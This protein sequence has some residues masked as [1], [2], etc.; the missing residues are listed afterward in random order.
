M[1]GLQLRILVS[2]ACGLVLPA[3]HQGNG[4]AQGMK[5]N[6]RSFSVTEVHARSE[7]K[8]SFCSGFTLTTTQAEAFF[9]R[10][11][12]IDGITLHEKFDWLPCYVDG[13]ISNPELNM[14]HCPF[15]IQAG[16]T[17]SIRC[18]GGKAFI[19]ACDQCEDLLAD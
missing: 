10:G 4:E 2:L 8:S 7:H 13:R 11:R 19:W 3:C 9:N 14:N 17:A 5:S 16:G 18:D 1:V 6:K 15:S 12:E